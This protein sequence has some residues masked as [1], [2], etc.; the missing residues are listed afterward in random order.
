MTEDQRKNAVAIARAIRNGRATVTESFAIGQVM[1][2]TG[3][4][5]DKAVKGLQAMRSEKLFE[6]FIERST[7]GA[8]GRMLGNC[9]ALGLLIARLDLVPGRCEVLEFRP[10]TY[11]APAI[12]ENRLNELKKRLFVDGF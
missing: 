2:V 7:D 10:F 9:P 8:L 12:A 11:P 4:P 3:C 5:Y 1:L 6:G